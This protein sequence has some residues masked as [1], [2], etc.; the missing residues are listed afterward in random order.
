L[1]LSDL[2]FRLQKNLLAYGDIDV[3]TD[4]DWCYVEPD[5][6][7]FD[8]E[9]KEDCENCKFDNEVCMKDKKVLIL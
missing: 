9:C 2:I 4:M 6:W 5:V 3:F 7:V 8:H 1:E